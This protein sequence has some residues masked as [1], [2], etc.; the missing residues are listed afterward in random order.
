MQAAIASGILLVSLF[1]QVGTAQTTIQEG[2]DVLVNLTILTYFVP[3]LYLFVALVLLDRQPG[4]RGRIWIVAI[5]G[6]ASTSIS[7]VLLFIPPAGT[8]SPLTFYV[9]LVGQFLALVG[10]GLLLARRGH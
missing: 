9:S 7:I 3:Y 6:L 10:V 2:Y 5:T 1:L 8:P 4:T